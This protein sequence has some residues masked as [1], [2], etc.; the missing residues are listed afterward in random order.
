MSME[1]IDEIMSEGLRVG[2]DTWTIEGILR[3]TPKVWNDVMVQLTRAGETTMKQLLLH[4]T[5]DG[6]PVPHF[7]IAKFS[8]RVVIDQAADRFEFVPIPPNYLMDRKQLDRG[9]P[10]GKFRIEHV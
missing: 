1:L 2:A 10:V 6:V 3:V 5:E 7:G 9:N 8:V 4:R